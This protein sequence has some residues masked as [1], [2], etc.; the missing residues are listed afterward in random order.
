MNTLP[1]SP[2]L[3]SWRWSDIRMTILKALPK[4]EEVISYNMPAYRLNGGIVLYFAGW[5]QHYS[6][7]PANEHLVTAF[8]TELAPYK[9]NR[10]TIRFPLSE[11]VPTKLIK[12]IV[13][14]RASGLAQR[15]KIRTPD[16]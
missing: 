6:I 13:K 4:A 16:K 14:F 12:R 5:K 3:R 15:D 2:R 1:H 10:G 8:K 9:V 7:Y 11:H